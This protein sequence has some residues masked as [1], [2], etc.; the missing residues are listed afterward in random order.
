[1]AGHFIVHTLLSVH[2]VFPH[3]STTAYRIEIFKTENPNSPFSARCYKRV[4]DNDPG[5]TQWKEDSGF[6][7]LS[8]KTEEDALPEALDH[9]D[10]RL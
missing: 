6:P 9:L 7:W 2:D 10:D 1:M 5:F 8:A 4:D 3:E